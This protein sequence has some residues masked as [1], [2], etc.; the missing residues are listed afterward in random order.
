MNL[1]DYCILAGLAIAVTA[2]VVWLIRRKRRGK[3]GCAGCPYQGN[4]SDKL[5]SGIQEQP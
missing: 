5:C 3:S 2:I 4:C 1:L